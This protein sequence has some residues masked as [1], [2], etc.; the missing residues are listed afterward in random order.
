MFE[1]ENADPSAPLKYASLRMTALVVGLTSK[2]NGN[3]RS[4]GFGQMTTTKY[5]RIV[6]A[7]SGGNAL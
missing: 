2:C 7:L 1:K 6:G 3:G 5:L 4:F